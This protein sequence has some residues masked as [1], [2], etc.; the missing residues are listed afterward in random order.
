MA[1]RMSVWATLC[2]DAD[3]RAADPEAYEAKMAA[4]AADIASQLSAARATIRDYGNAIGAQTD[5]DAEL[6]AADEAEIALSTE[7]D[8]AS[9]NR[10]LGITA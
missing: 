3:E 6:D 8:T 1:K 4:R 10:R 7:L 5:G 2:R 9:R